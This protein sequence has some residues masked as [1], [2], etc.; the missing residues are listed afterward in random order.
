M[1]RFQP[2]SARCPCHAC[3][4]QAASGQPQACPHTSYRVCCSWASLGPEADLRHQ[5]VCLANEQRWPHSQLC[6]CPRQQPNFWVR[7]ED[8]SEHQGCGSQ[9]GTAV[10]L[11]PPWGTQLNQQR[12]GGA[13]MSQ[14]SHLAAVGCLCMKMGMPQVC[15]SCHGDMSSLHVEIGLQGKPGLT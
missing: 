8:P 12:L 6:P 9:R 14:C 13:D 1:C 2:R 11:C 4:C 15:R 5:P 7:G 10:P 3:R